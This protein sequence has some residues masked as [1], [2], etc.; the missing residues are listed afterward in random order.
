MLT[1]TLSL[2]IADAL[3]EQVGRVRLRRGLLPIVDRLEVVLPAGTT[4]DAA[5]GDDVIL[6]LDGGE[7]STTVFTGSLGAI[8]HGLRSLRVT[9]HGFAL[10][11][12]RARP[13][14]AYEKLSV[15]E[16]VERLTEDL[17][18]ALSIRDADMPT[19]LFVCEGRASALE[20]IVRVC[21][22][23]G[24]QAAFDGEGSLQIGPDGP[25]DALALRYGRELIDVASAAWSADPNEF[26]VAGEGGGAPDSDQSLWVAKDFFAGSGTAAGTGVRWRSEPLIRRVDDARTAG[27][28]WTTAQRRRE[29]P[30]RMQTWLLPELAPGSTIDVE[31]LPDHLPLPTCM[32]RQVVHEI[33]PR[34][35]GRSS[36]WACSADAGGG[37]LAGLGGLF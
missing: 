32:V 11:L 19:A 10:T 21:A 25:G 9:A 36:V 30:I 29:A 37:L 15:Q 27:E 12:A 23:A 1:P 34:F 24:L 17:E 5:L 18:I 35:G 3:Y 7:G 6:E 16:V 26:T 8:Q 4:L 2:Q 33:D 14:G 13:A 20:L 31:D 28:A 22:M